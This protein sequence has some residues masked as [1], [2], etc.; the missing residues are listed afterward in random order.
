MCGATAPADAERCP[1]C[2]LPLKTDRKRTRRPKR[3]IAF[4]PP[5]TILVALA[6]VAALVALFVYLATG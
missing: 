1:S 5:L 3:H 2:D 4:P 6:L